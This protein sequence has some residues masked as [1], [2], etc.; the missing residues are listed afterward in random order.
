MTVDCDGYK[1]NFEIKHFSSQKNQN[2]SSS[3][4]QNN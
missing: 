2:F 4:Q 3:Q 1:Q